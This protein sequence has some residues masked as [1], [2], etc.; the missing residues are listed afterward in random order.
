LHF[1]A[2]YSIDEA[3]L[4]I[5][6]DIGADIEARDSNNKTRLHYAVRHEVS[7]L[8]LTTFLL[9]NGAN[10]EAR[11]SD[12]R[13]TSSYRLR[14]LHLRRNCETLGFKS[15]LLASSWTRELIVARLVLMDVR[16]GA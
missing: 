12:G 6:L 4:R 14:Y 16:L 15:G 11:T 10:I 3:P 2:W 5:L 13:K 7:G 8:Q 9:E 1:S